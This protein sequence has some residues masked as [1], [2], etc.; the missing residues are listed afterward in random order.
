MF[1]DQEHILK[2]SKQ[3]SEISVTNTAKNVMIILIWTVLHVILDTST[4]RINVSRYDLMVIITITI[5]I[6]ASHEIKHA[7]NDLVV[8]SIN[9]QN[10]TQL[11]YIFLETHSVL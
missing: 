4:M 11:Y 9:A 5:V 3:T 6:H 7:L 2:I 1:N 8:A 10:V